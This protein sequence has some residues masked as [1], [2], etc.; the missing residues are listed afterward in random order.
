MLKCQFHTHVLGDPED[1]IKFTGKELIK[2]AKKLNYNVLS[3]TCHNKIIFTKSMK[4]YAEKKG[5]LL[6][7]GIEL[8]INK[9]HILVINPNENIYKIKTFND[10][11]NYKNTNKNCLIIAPHP[12]FPDIVSLKKELE[13]YIDIFDA[14][15]HCWAYTKYINFNKKAEKLAK[16]FNKPLIST[17]DC[18]VLKYFN[19]AGYCLVDAKQNTNSIIKAIKENKIKNI[20]SPTSISKIL[21]TLI[22]V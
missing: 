11:R 9:K 19:S 6:I 16:K 7:P 10:L 1:R 13:N 4:K 14:I 17:L 2:K 15:E 22:Q 12:F 8:S 3:I 18:H 5:I 20:H 21:N